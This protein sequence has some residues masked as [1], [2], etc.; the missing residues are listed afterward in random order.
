[1]IDVMDENIHEW[2]FADHR[3]SIAAGLDVQIHVAPPQFSVIPTTIFCSGLARN[4]REELSSF[5]GRLDAPHPTMLNRSAACLC[6]IVAK[7][8]P[9]LR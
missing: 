2:H 5:R 1:M 3:S 8:K 9:Y 6:D 4:L 7:S